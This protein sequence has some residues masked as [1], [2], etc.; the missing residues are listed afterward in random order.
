MPNPPSTP[1]RTS[2]KAFHE[3]NQIK[4]Q[5]TVELTQKAIARLEAEGRPVTLTAVC[6]TTRGLDERGKGLRPISLLRN[7][8][9]AELFRQHSPAYQ[10]RQQKA[11]KAKR[12][13]A[14]V[15][16]D[17]R[18]MYRG[19]RASDLIQIIEDLKAQLAEA[20][21]HQDRLKTQREDA[22]RLR[23]EALQQNAQQLAALTQLTVKA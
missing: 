4:F 20:K 19:L 1:K 6:E 9:A 14:K 3:H 10:A 17:T 18:T 22:Y 21:A 12:K 5:R 7:P 23:D 16:A 2:P 13:R 11:R 15:N 8:E